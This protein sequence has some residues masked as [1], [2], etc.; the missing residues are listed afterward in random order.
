MPGTDM[1]KVAITSR[2]A[3]SV[4]TRTVGSAIYNMCVQA[5]NVISSNVRVTLA[6]P[7]APFPP[8]PPIYIYIY[9][10]F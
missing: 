6:I 9:I 2:N 3:G 4:R 1:V 5:S 7:T 8:N 10:F